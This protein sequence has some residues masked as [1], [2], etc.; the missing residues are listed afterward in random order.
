MPCVDD[1]VALF[2]AVLLVDVSVLA[3]R[4]R[5]GIPMDAY[6]PGVA[7]VATERVVAVAG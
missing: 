4:G 1:E 5:S 7:M 6:R 2:L 3:I